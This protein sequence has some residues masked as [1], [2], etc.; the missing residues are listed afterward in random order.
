MCLFDLFHVLNTSQPASC[1]AVPCEGPTG[2]N[3][4]NLFF[5]IPADSSVAHFMN[6][7]TVTEQTCYTLFFLSKK[8]KNAIN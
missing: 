2:I 4:I 3:S 7:I 5:N 6:H 1:A 8:K